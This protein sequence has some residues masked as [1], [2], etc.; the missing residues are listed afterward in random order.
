MQVAMADAFDSYK[1]ECSWQWVKVAV[2]RFLD[3]FLC[4]RIIFT[5]C[6]G[7]DQ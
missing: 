4:G 1:K 7:Y 3:G 5:C 6:C 2:D